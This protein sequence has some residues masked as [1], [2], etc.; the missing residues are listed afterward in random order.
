ML[1]HHILTALILSL[2]AVTGVS[3]QV[4]KEKKIPKAL[5]VAEVQTAPEYRLQQT[6][7]ISMTVYREPDMDTQSMIG[8]SGTVSFPLLGAVEIKGLTVVEA[9]NK[10]KQLYEKD[11]LV[12][13]MVRIHV[14]S[15]AKKWVSIAGAVENGGNIPYPE[16]GILTLSSA[17]AMAG[18]VMQTGNSKRITVARKKGGASVYTLTAGAKVF[19][20]PGDTVVVPRL[21]IVSAEAKRLPT[22]TIS[23]EVKRP[24]DVALLDGK[25]DILSAIAKAGGFSRI[26]NQ[27]EAILQ[28][29]SKGGYR[30][31]KVSLRNITSGKAPMVY[32]YPGDI[33]IIRESAF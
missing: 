14:T 4:K 29:K 25:I 9:E 10:L 1:K 22:C 27:K 3:A 16:E 5:E 23:G 26:A 20:N 24:G 6:D 32:L 31:A 15:Y 2:C 13:A 11:Y 18:G 12:S 30:H 8:K 21:P 19:L 33:L 7:E 28:I 17:I